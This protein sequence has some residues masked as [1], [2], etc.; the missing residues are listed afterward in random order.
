MWPKKPD[1]LHHARCEAYLH[2]T[3]ADADKVEDDD[4]VLHIHAVGGLQQQTLGG[5]HNAPQLAVQSL[6]LA[7]FRVA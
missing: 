3:N 5:I 1:P 4:M 6:S 7:A 2:G